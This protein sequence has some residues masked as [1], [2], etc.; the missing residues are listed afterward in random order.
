MKRRSSEALEVWAARGLAIS[1]MQTAQEP[2]A[3]Q[4]CSLPLEGPG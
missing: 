4:V 3:K 2:H 1:L